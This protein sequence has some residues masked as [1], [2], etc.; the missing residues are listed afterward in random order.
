MSGSVLPLPASDRW[1]GGAG[2]L[3]TA[4]SGTVPN[5]STEASLERFPEKLLQPKKSPGDA[6][7]ELKVRLQEPRGN[8]GREGLT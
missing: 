6:G 8:I 7:L 1:G 5:T 3:S 2:W 4:R